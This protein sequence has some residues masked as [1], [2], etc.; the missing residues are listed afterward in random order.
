MEQEMLNGSVI[1]AQDQLQA[2]PREFWN[3][4]DSAGHSPR[5]WRDVLWTEL[6]PPKIHVWKPNPVKWCLKL[7]S[8]GD[9]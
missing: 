5:S 9:N 6:R 4:H 8:L 7:E 3:T 1:S 2:D